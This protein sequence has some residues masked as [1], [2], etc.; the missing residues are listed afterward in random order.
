MKVYL[1]GEREAIS[2]AGGERSKWASV[3]KRRLFSYYYHGFQDTNRISR[4]IKNSA[5]MGLDLFLDSGAFT[6]FTKGAVIDP[7]RYAE[8]IHDSAKVWTTCSS[9]D[10]IGDPAKTYEYF[11]ILRSMG[12]KV[13]PVFHCREDELWLRK[14][15][16]EG[17]DYIFLGGMVPEQTNW[18]MN[19]LDGLWRNYLTNKDGTARVKIHGFGLTDQRLIFRYPWYS[20]DST[21]WLMIGVYGGCSF[22]TPSGL[23]KVTFSDSSPQLKDDGSWHYKQLTPPLRQ[24]VD[25]WLK[26]LGV[27]AE[28]VGTH[29]SYRD[30]VN[31]ATYQRMEAFATNRFIDPQEYLF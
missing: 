10:A 3:V 6:A 18:L 9:L 1:A 17:Y 23:R 15:L 21:S 27:T 28:Q 22:M 2:K 11:K 31:A 12:C 4:D 25:I 7:E 29:Y 19:W 20:V 8:Y 30:M 26:E 5:E 16:D 13:Q 14:Y 24:Q